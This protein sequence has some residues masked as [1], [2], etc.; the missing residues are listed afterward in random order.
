MKNPVILLVLF[1]LAA[2]CYEPDHSKDVLNNVC[3][4][5]RGKYVCSSIVFKGSPIDINGDGQCNTDLLK[6]FNT[7][8]NC[9]TAIKAFQ[10]VNVAMDY[11][12]EIS[13]NLE[14]PIQ[15]VDFDKRTEEYRA[16]ISGGNMH[17]AF[18][19]SVA[20]DGTLA[21]AV[22][23][24]KNSVLWREG[25]SEISQ[26][27]NKLTEGERIVSLGGGRLVAL[28]NCAY[29]DHAT[30]TFVQNQAEFIYERGSYS[31]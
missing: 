15:Y 22:H 18:S 17:V 3:E 11:N 29:F 24:E 13:V 14:I 31:L 2:G 10:W 25:D 1:L 12:T 30:K 26:L 5:L 16:S 7:L 19:Y 6:E 27:D 28:I 23:N 20:E 21:F 9:M 8:S 4:G